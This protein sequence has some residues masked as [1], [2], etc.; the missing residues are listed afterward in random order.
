MTAQDKPKI[1]TA[2]AR[3]GISTL[4]AI[5]ENCF[6]ASLRVL[7]PSHDPSKPNKFRLNR[8]LKKNTGQ[9]RAGL[10]R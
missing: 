5:L 9:T 3:M 4:I 10:D 7:D 8:L 6:V 1:M 2:S